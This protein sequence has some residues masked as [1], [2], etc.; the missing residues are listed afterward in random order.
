[1]QFLFLFQPDPNAFHLIMDVDF[2]TVSYNKIPLTPVFSLGK[3]L[4]QKHK[5]NVVD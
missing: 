3:R 4:Y 1:M 2:I 5:L